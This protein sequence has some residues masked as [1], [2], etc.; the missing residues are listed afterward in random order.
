MGRQAPSPR[1][2]LPQ[3]TRAQAWLFESP[4]RA[5]SISPRPGARLLGGRERKQSKVMQGRLLLKVFFV[6]KAT[7][8]ACVSGSCPVRWL[9]KRKVFCWRA[10][11]LFLAARLSFIDWVGL[12]ELGEMQK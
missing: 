1:A 7:F 11:P 5:Q 6:W 4:P 8:S 12:Q 10:A 9:R 2:P 3:P